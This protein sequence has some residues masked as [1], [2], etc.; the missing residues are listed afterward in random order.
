[1]YRSCTGYA[2]Q[3]TWVIYHVTQVTDRLQVTGYTG[4]KQKGHQVTG[5]VQVMR[6]RLHG[7]YTM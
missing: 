3:V 5:Y 4:Y 2:R 7:L 1:M 6:D